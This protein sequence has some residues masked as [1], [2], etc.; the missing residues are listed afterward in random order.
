[1]YKIGDMIV[2]EGSQSVCRVSDIA[3]LDFRGGNENRLYYVLKPMHQNCV[4][5]N[6]VDNADALMRPVITRAEAEKLIEGIPQMNVAEM[7]VAARPF[8][9]GK[10]AAQYYESIIRTRDCANLIKL[11]MS[12]YEKKQSLAKHDRHIGSMEAAAM[13][14]AEDMLFDEL[15]VA[16][17]IPKER[18]QQYIGARIDG[19]LAHGEGSGPE[20]E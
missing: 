6:P 8:Q 18:V 9:E 13:K 17:D 7:S 19:K 2:Y 15:A 4:I 5:Y 10:Q 3:A 14:R 16:L 20:G 11:V 1:M 12:I